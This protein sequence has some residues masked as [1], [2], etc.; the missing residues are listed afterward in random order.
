MASANLADKAQALG[1]KAAN[2]A[3]N[4]DIGNVGD[5]VADKAASAKS[6]VVR[7]AKN[8]LSN[9]PNVNGL[10]DRA[11][12]TASNLK[13]NAQS[14]ARQGAGGQAGDAADAVKRGIR[15]V[16]VGR[17]SAQ[18]LCE[19]FVG[20]FGWADGRQTVVAAKAIDVLVVPACL[21]VVGSSWAVLTEPLSHPA[22]PCP[23]SLPPSPWSSRT[24]CGALLTTPPPTLTVWAVPSRTPTAW[25]TARLPSA[26]WT[27]SLSLPASPRAA[28]LSPTPR[29]LAAR[30][31]ECPM[32]F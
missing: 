29:T 9:A 2:A 16:K 6:S 1:D 24:T 20:C 13:D 28:T 7:G 30:C 19:S 15:N 23:D 3:S 17:C 32:R 26:M 22:P 14:V 8:A 5:K 27:I 4:I 10:G 25:L 12:E 31:S 21:L 18:D 11:S